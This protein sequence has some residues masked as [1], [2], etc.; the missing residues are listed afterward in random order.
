MQTELTP[1]FIYFAKKMLKSRDHQF[2][3]AKASTS[4]W[5]SEAK[6]LPTCP[7]STRERAL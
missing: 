2:G 3:R 1:Y 6:Y 5:G 4:P 7:F